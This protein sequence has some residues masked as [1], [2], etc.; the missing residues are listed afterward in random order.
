MLNEFREFAIKGNVVDLAVG[1]IIG[2][3]FGKIVDSLVND[4]VMPTIGA[5][6]GRLDFSSH[7][8]ALHEAPPGTPMTLDA[9]RKAGVPVLAWGQFVTVAVNFLILAF[10]IFLLVQQINRLRR[11]HQQEPTP[12]PAA[13][14][15]PPPEDILLLRE[16]RDELKKA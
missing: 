14:P 15:A 11:L 12:A 6:I 9:L 1:V 5:I 10:V 2:G 7:F 8:I 16:I 3:A 13:E 4:I